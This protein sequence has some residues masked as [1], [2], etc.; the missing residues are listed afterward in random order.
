MEYRGKNYSVILTIGGKWK[1]SAEIEGQYRPGMAVSRPLRQAG[2]ARDRQGAGAEKETLAA[3]RM[4]EAANWGGLT[5]R[6]SRLL[7]ASTA[8]QPTE[9][10]RSKVSR[11]ARIWAMVAQPNFNLGGCR[12]AD[13]TQLS[14]WRA[15]SI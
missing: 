2:G 10:A 1:W 5:A 4:K 9:A 8:H 6:R 3:S 7:Q 14:I 11:V 12:P 15:V 13:E